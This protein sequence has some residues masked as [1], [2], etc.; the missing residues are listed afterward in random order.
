LPYQ[1]E[2]EVEKEDDEWL[3]VVEWMDV[4]FAIPVIQ[5][6]VNRPRFGCYSQLPTGA[7]WSLLMISVSTWLPVSSVLSA[8]YCLE[9]QYVFE[10]LVTSEYDRK[11]RQLLPYTYLFTARNT[12]SLVFAREDGIFIPL[13]IHVGSPASMPNTSIFISL[14]TWQR[15]RAWS[16]TS[17][18]NDVNS[19]KRCAAE[20]GIFRRSYPGSR[21]HKAASPLAWS[22]VSSTQTLAMYFRRL[23]PPTTVAIYLVH[24]I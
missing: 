15:R 12:G 10:S 11:I 7:C 22:R 3:G 20:D 21:E 13:G 6:V 18:I 16:P 4:P 24:V 1:V 5:D 19:T 14:D 17:A 9:R 23:R 2:E 8:C